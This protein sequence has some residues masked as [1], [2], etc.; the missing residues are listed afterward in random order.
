[1]AGSMD[2]I[3][4]AINKLHEGLKSTQHIAMDEGH[5]DSVND[6]VYDALKAIPNLNEDTMLQEFDSFLLE[7]ARAKGFLRMTEAERV[8]YIRL[9]FEDDL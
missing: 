8:N 2:V 4:E 6:K 1:M 7:S 5:I 9:R 3:C